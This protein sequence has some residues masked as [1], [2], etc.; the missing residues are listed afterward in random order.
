[1]LAAVEAQMPIPWNLAVFVERL[2]AARGRG[3]E[4]IP[5]DFAHGGDAPTGL[6]LP[7]A[8]ADYLFFDAAASPARREQ[9]IGHELGHMLLDHAPRLAGAPP[10]FLQGLAPSL[11]PALAQRFLVMA[12]TGYAT[13]EEA[14][15]E[16]FGTSLIRLGT[17]RHTSGGRDER[18][19]LMDV[20]R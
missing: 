4:L 14:V 9:I 12:R 13:E 17:S 1:V 10:D 6:W 16:E 15:A 19:R 18:G 20:L 8:R 7:T 11:S 2:A 3:I 5:W